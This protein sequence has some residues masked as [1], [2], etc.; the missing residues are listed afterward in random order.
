MFLYFGGV[1]VVVLFL[2]V[3]WTP[4]P[5][6]L[7]KTPMSSLSVKFQASST[8]PY[9]RL[10][11][12]LL[13][14]TPTLKIYPGVW[15]KKRMF[16]IVVHFNSLETLPKFGTMIILPAYLQCNEWRSV[17]CVLMFSLNN[18]CPQILQFMESNNNIMSSHFTCGIFTIIRHVS[19]VAYLQEHGL[20]FWKS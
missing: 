16:R 13:L 9:D 7:A 15:Q 18:Y 3:T 4:K 14:S 8:P 1:L 6:K 17:S 11:W 5:L 2:L 12:V 19:G 20:R 10:W